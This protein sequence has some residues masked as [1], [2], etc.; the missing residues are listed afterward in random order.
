[1]RLSD[2]FPYWDEGIPALMLTDTALFRNPNYHR[3][4]DLPETLDYSI[5]AM[6]TKQV[7]ASLLLLSE[8][9]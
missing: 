3:S 9:Q 1:L 6:I 5:M 7:A 8:D 4:S 2:Q